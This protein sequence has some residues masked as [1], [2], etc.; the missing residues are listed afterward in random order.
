[1]GRG[2]LVLSL[3][4]GVGR[5]GLGV[6]AGE[7]PAELGAGIRVGGRGDAS[8]KTGGAGGGR[9]GGGGGAAGEGR[10]KMGEGTGWGGGGDASE[11]TGQAASSL[12]GRARVPR[13]SPTPPSGP[14]RLFLLLLLSLRLS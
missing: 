12:Q 1:M 13:I 5:R 9:G 7:E 8:E 10:G 3:R 14:R 11:K 6:G 4:T 2:R